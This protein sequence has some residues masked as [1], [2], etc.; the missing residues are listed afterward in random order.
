[1][2]TNPPRTHLHREQLLRLLRAAC[3]QDGPDGTRRT[4][5][6]IARDA[7]ISRSMLSRLEHG[8]RIGSADIIPGLAHALRVDPGWLVCRCDDPASH[9]ADVGEAA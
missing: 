8:S 3:E 5:A 2:D 1:M 4:R 6:S 7:R 9:L